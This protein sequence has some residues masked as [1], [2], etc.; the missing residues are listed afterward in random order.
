M[1][2]L[3]STVRKDVKFLFMKYLLRPLQHF[4]SWFSLGTAFRQREPKKIQNHHQDASSKPDH[5]EMISIGHVRSVYNEKFGTPRQGSLVPSGRGSLVL[6]RR[7]VDVQWSLD[8]LE[9]YSHV[10]L[11]FVFHTNTNA[12]GKSTPSSKVRPPQGAGAKVGVF[13]TRTPH[14]PNPLGLTM[15]KIR[16]VDTTAGIVYLEALDLCDGT[17]VLDIKPY[18]EHVDWPGLNVAVTPDWVSNPKFERAEVTFSEEALTSLKHLVDDRGICIWYRKGESEIVKQAIIEIVSLDPRDLNRG[19]GTFSITSSNDKGIPVK[20]SSF[21]RRENKIK[22]KAATRLVYVR[23]DELDVTFRPAD[24]ESRSF[25][26][27][28]IDAFKDRNIISVR[29]NKANDSIE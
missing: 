3:I 5:F 19:R 18:C 28:A 13:A 4:L 1:I 7:A 17:P 10:W 2:R 9:Q 8:A 15:A 11:L 12:T 20:E 27:L 6:D 26:I 24:E 25:H 22:E 14:R 29:K 16:S 23:F 21:T